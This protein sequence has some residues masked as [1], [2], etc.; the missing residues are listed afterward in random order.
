[1][2]STIDFDS[3]GAGSIPA[4]AVPIHIIF[5]DMINVEKNLFVINL[6][7]ITYQIER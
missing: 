2:V 6:C 1:M 4:I 3:I 7:S 5:H